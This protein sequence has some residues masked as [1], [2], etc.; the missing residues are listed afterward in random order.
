MPSFC[1]AVSIVIGPMPAIGPFSHKK[2][3][4]TIRPPLSATSE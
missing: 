2:L 3:L 4:P 1:A